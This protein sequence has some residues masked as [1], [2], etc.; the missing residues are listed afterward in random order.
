[1]IQNESMPRSTIIPVLGYTDV[2]QA[3][4]WLVRTFGFK[5]RLRIA[6]H[7]AQLTYAGGDLIVT[8]S[9]ALVAPASH[10]IMVRVENLD[11]HYLRSREAGAH[12]SCEPESFPYGE[13]QYSVSDIGGHAWTFS[14]SV[15]DIEPRTWGG[16]LSEDAGRQFMPNPLC[17]SV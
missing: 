13:R 7:R 1:M 8:Q 17:G 2:P 14:Q 11:V 15:A 12:I 10:S 5:E 4:E 16:T 6:D 9:S 3:V